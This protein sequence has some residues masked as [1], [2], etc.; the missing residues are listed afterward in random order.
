MI[1]AIGGTQ[2]CPLCGG[3]TARRAGP[4]ICG[5]CGRDLI[6][7]MQP[8]AH[9]TSPDQPAVLGFVLHAPPKLPAELD[10]CVASMTFR[11]EGDI[12]PPGSP[13][14]QDV[15]G[16]RSEVGGNVVFQ[17]Q[18][19]EGAFGVDLE[20]RFLEGTGGCWIYHGSHQIKVVRSENGQMIDTSIVH[21]DVHFAGQQDA[22]EAPIALDPHTY[23]GAVI[24][25]NGYE[26]V[27]VPAGTFPMGSPRG[28]V[29]RY[30]DEERREVTLERPFFLGRTPV[31]QLLWEAVTGEKPSQYPGL[32]N[33]V[34]NVTWTDAV[35]FCNRLSAL[36]GL[37]EVYE[38]RGEGW[39]PHPER[40]GYR[41]PTETEWEHAARRGS[42]HQAYAGSGNPDEVAVHGRGADQGTEAV[43]RLRGNKLGL[44]DMCGNVAEWVEDRFDVPRG[45]GAEPLTSGLRVNRGGGWC[46]PPRDVRIACRAHAGELRY[47]A[48]FVGLRMARTI[49]RIEERSEASIS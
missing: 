48:P 8:K 47:K 25:A 22:P 30:E 35:H 29:G 13:A 43:G 42:P 40:P 2:G 41:L 39:L 26:M 38:P 33:P 4:R 18:P 23:G 31:T 36:E 17:F 1:A 3:G 34:E 32:T 12:R 9:S 15:S 44:L 19:R 6:L 27:W 45:D 28:E 21:G 14:P 49:S 5:T 20:V 10:R 11:R 24:N 16:V 46:D 37:P 7:Q